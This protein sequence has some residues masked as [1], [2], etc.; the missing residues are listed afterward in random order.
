MARLWK[1]VDGE[2]YMINPRLG[3]LGLQA[4]QA[5]NPKG[6]KMA[7][8]RRS[9]A[10]HMAWVRSFRKSN[11]RRRHARRRRN[12]YPMAGTVAG[13]LNPRRRRRGR[14]HN[15][16]RRHYRRNPVSVRSVRGMMGL[17]PLMPVVWSTAGFAATAA[18]Q[19]FID[20]LVPASFKTNAD[21]TPNMITKYAEIAASIVVVTWGGK[22]LLGSGPSTFLGIGGGVYAVQTVVHDFL[23]G[24]IPGM[25]AYTPLKAYT[26]LHPSSSLSGMGRSIDSAGG[27]MPGLA[28]RRGMPGLALS[29]PDH[30][31][32]NN[33]NFAADGAMDM[34]PARFR[35]FS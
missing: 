30:G 14:K 22:M 15:P 2:P 5:L 20:T 9:G 33:A 25:H 1:V 31:A 7:R 13:I 35:R 23:P 11:T 34:A 21:G 24:V 18:V 26:P 19:G 27:G 16:R 12:P 32:M 6:R 29:A 28:L 17:P 4:L 3:I 8:H 10:R